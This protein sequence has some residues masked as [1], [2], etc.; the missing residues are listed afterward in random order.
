MLLR[1][2]TARPCS[3]SCSGQVLHAEAESLGAHLLQCPRCATVVESLS[4]E[5]TLVEAVQCPRS[6]RRD[7]RGS[8][9][10]PAGT[11]EGPARDAAAGAIDTPFQKPWGQSTGHA[12]CPPP[13]GQPEQFGFLAPPQGPDELGWLA[14]YRVLQ[15][16]GEGGM[17]MVFLAV[18]S[19]LQRPVALKLLKPDLARDSGARQRFLREARAMAAVKSDHVVTVHQVGLDNDVPFLAMEF[20]QGEPLDTWLEGNER[21]TLAEVL[22]LGREIAVGLAA[23]HALG[24]IHRDI[25]PGNIWLEALPAGPEGVGSRARVKILDFGLARI[26]R[27]NVHL[28]ETGLIVGTPSY[29]APEQARGDKLDARCDLFSLGCILYRLCTGR[30]PFQGEST[31]ALLTALALDDPKPVAN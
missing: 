1:V 9:P 3:G 26:T 2:P 4:A 23:A 21:P 6:R 5:D 29:M 22:W 31:M 13:Q 20:L 8:H 28:T 10:G 24:L 16:Q 17:G 12:L 25:K 18:D 14:H 30:L 27:E 11:A 15:L 19:H 7:A